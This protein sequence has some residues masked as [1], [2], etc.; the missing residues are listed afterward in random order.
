L[1]VITAQKMAGDNGT[2]AGQNSLYGPVGN[3]GGPWP[4]AIEGPAINQT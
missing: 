1:N 4:G 3:P 2:I